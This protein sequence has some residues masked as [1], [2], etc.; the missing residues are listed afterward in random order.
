MRKGEYTEAMAIHYASAELSRRGWRVDLPMAGNR[1]GFDLTATKGKE[2][3]RVEV[4]GLRSSAQF[5]FN[6]DDWYDPEIALPAD[7]VIGVRALEDQAPEFFIGTARE[8]QT[9]LASR[10]N[11]EWA[12]W[13]DQKMYRDRWDKL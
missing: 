6:A 10:P 12:P 8:V 3:L 7:N 4:K 9:D 13:R 2:T 5:Y 11:S 1:E